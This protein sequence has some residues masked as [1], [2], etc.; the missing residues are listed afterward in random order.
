MEETNSLKN[1]YAVASQHCSIN[2]VIGTCLGCRRASKYTVLR[3]QEKQRTAGGESLQ[4]L[5]IV[6][7]HLSV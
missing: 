3:Q 2:S 6:S 7:Q 1:S 5:F 4:M